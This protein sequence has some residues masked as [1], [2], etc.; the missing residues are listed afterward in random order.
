M[1]GIL[2]CEHTLA[3]ANA[4]AGCDRKLKMRANSCLGFDKPTVGLHHGSP[5]LGPTQVERKD[6]S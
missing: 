4:C 3:G 6:G 1:S 5:D 2:N